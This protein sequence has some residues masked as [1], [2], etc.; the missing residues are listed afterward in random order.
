MPETVKVELYCPPMKIF[1]KSMTLR[2]T[3]VEPMTLTIRALGVEIGGV[4]I[5][6]TDVRPVFLW[7]LR[8]EVAACVGENAPSIAV[9]VRCELPPE[10]V[11]VFPLQKRAVAKAIWADLFVHVAA[12]GREGR[13]RVRF[14]DCRAKLG[15]DFALAEEVTARG[16]LT[17][18]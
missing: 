7:P 17:F 10:P 11:H 1:R 2:R 8:W 9:Y 4:V 13:G 15:R 5:P 6:E 14:P 12:D 3:D 16:T 18:P